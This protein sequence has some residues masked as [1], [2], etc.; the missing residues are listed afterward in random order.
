MQTAPHFNTIVIVGATSLI[1]Q[2]CARQWLQAS[3][4]R[5]LVLVG[6][7][8]ARLESVANDLRVRAPQATVDVALADLTHAASIETMAERV[9]AL[10]TPDAVLI[11]HGDLPDQAACQQQLADAQAAM[12][13]NGLSPVLCAEAFAR[14]MQP[15]GRGT[16]GIIG[17]VAGDRGRKSNYVYGAA[18]GLVE[19]YAQ[20]LQHRF[21]GT[22]ISVVLIKPGPTDTPMTAHLKAGG[23]RLA[24]VES[25]AAA[26]VAGMQRGTPVVYAPAKW[27]LIM[28]VIRS[29]PRAIFNKMDI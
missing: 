1:A 23:A 10:C 29:L 11:A 21:A 22:G 2:H 7:D 14:A 24:S 5:R 15:M 3:P 25:V 27:A 9:Q 17:S 18:K 4:A 12:V 26:T 19:R 16:I 8:A 13:V 6:R 28:L 20:G